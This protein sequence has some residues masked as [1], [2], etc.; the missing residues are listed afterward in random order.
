[1]EL[2]LKEKEQLLRD[3]D[4][5]LAALGSEAKGLTESDSARER[6][7]SLLLQELQNRTELLQVK[8][9]I[10]KELE[11]RLNRTAKALENA[12]SEMARRANQRDG[13][14]S[15]PL[16]DQLTKIATPKD[17]VEALLRPDR[18]GL[19]SQLLELGAAKARAASL[20]A[21]DI[22]H[23]KEANN[24]P[25]EAPGEIL[26]RVQDQSVLLPDDDG[27]SETDNEP[28]EELKTELTKKDGH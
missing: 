24:S 16:G 7:K 11:E 6:A 10:V 20:Q 14:L 15:T 12:Q 18:K 5:E 3:R 21:E 27:L 19:N 13:K 8:D 25:I 28:Q 26:S 9:A 22:K 4:T 17:Q 23:A 2:Q 1:L